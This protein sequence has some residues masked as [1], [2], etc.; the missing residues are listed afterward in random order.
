MATIDANARAQN[1][2]RLSRRDLLRKMIARITDAAGARP[3]RV[4]V[5]PPV[6]QVPYVPY[7]SRPKQGQA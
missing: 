3:A 1:E 4:S 5:R 6:L 2:E 7:T